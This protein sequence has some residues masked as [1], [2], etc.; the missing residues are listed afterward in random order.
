MAG[1]NEGQDCRSNVQ[2]SKDSMAR[3]TTMV[4]KLTIENGEITKKEGQRIIHDPKIGAS[5]INYER[6]EEE[7]IMGGEIVVVLNHLNLNNL[8]CMQRKES[9]GSPTYDCRSQM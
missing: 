5:H 2:D 1:N 8:D 7:L 6:E 3:G 9:Y 4:W